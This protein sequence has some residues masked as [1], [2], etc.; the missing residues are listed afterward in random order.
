[1]PAEAI[2]RRTRLTVRASVTRSTTA[3]RAAWQVCGH[4][5]HAH[6]HAH[7]H[8]QGE[9]NEGC[10][11]GEGCEEGEKGEEGGLG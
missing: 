10:G 7:A 1:M 9:E 8:A 2:T 11:E 3:C 5:V 4:A 6:V